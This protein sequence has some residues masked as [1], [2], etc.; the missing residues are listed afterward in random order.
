MFDKI[1]GSIGAFSY[2]NRKIISVISFILFV[3]VL[4]ASTQLIIEYSYA[5]ESIVT[6][7]FPQDDTIVLVYDG[8]D[9]AKMEEI[10]Q[11][12]EKDEHVTL[13][14]GYANTLGMKMSASDLSS[15]MGIPE[16]FVNTLFYIKENGM[17]VTD[18]TLV[19]FV[20]FIASDEFLN[21]ELFSSMIDDETKGQLTQMKSL[22]DALA[23]EE[24]YSAEEIAGILGVEKQLVKSIFFI[25]QMKDAHITNITPVFWANV[26]DALGMDEENIER[27]FGVQPVRSLLFTEFVD[28]ITEVAKYADG[29]LD[30]EQMAQLGM[31][32]EM[33]DMVREGR[34]FA[35][36]ELAEF[37]AS[38]A[39]SD[40]LNENTLTLLY[41][42]AQSSAVDLSEVR[43]PLYDFFIFLSEEILTSEAFS[44]FFDE[45]VTA[46]FEEAKTTM[47]EGLAQLVGEDHSRMVI[48][49]NYEVESEEIYAFYDNFNAMLASTLSGEYY[50]VG[51]TAMSYEVSQSFESEYLIISVVTAVAVFAVVWFTFK[52]FF[53]ALMLVGVIECAVFSMMSVMVVIN[54][55][56]YFIPLILVQCI[57]MGSMIDYGILFTTYYME[58]R[59]EYS[60]EEALPEVMRRATH[61]IL[62]SSL[63]I[64][65]VTL[66]CGRLMSGA[67][68][69]ILTTLGIGSLCA[70]LLI[71][72]V[73]PS[74]LSVFDKIVVKQ[75]KEEIDE[76]D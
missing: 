20:T 50:L 35:P 76:F 8:K 26:A 67:V 48:T 4:I 36:R 46:Q 55:P 27:V 62:T 16:M 5:E 51:A 53:L 6:D 33:S 75:E 17:E 40:M 66:I 72:F 11:Y 45:N 32:K 49:L 12:L 56:M 58:V 15:M 71:L 68:A 34:E 18:M 30:E 22:V 69:S 21:N 7:I 24:E 13:V 52:K 28:I 65:L 14:Q 70:I 57:L 43:V 3:A 59:K 25:A 19:D 41:I 61:S 63:L 37:F 54:L 2:R 23:S 9:E 44:S 42:M 64:V 38:V 74:L 39:E 73:L 10:I 31:L 60:V 47:Q 29:I 1:V